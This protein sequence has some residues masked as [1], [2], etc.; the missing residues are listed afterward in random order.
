MY[1]NQRAIAEFNSD[2]AAAWS[3]L[4]ELL[5]LSSSIESP[6]ARP[7]RAGERL[8]VAFAALVLFFQGVRE[9]GG[10]SAG[11]QLCV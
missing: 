7:A 1:I 2:K 6:V 3:K 9:E 10:L 8:Q 4:L 5:F 11:P